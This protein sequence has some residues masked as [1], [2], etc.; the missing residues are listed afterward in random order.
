MSM[1]IPGLSPPPMPAMRRQEPARERPSESA[2][3]SPA[4]G[5]PQL[6]GTDGLALDAAAAATAT[7]S[8]PVPDAEGTTPATAEDA[9]RLAE[10]L[11]AD[12]LASPGQAARAHG[13]LVP[14]TVLNLLA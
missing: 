3:P 2:A 14:A 4:P 8:P 13:N 6:V 9:R 1:R 7:A 11:R 10:R 5:R 12:T